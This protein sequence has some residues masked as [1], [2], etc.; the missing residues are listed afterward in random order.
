MH[1]AGQLQDAYYL[2]QSKL[3][4]YYILVRDNGDYV[5]IERFAV[6]LFKAVENERLLSGRTKK[7]LQGHS[8]NFEV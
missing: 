4:F 5:S 8:M 6:F 3:T 2:N 7:P 1:E